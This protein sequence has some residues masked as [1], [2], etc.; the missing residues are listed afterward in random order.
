MDMRTKREKA[1][2]R[3]VSFVERSI[4]DPD[5]GN[6][7]LDYIEELY[8]KKGADPDADNGGHAHTIPGIKTMLMSHERFSKYFVKPSKLESARAKYAALKNN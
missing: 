3:L 4:S 1:F 2:D 5:D 7:A 8:N 6:A